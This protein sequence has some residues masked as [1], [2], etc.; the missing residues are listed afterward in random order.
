MKFLTYIRIE[1]R[2]R[3]CSTYAVHWQ[4]VEEKKWSDKILSYFPSSLKLFHGILSVQDSS[5]E[6][7][8][9][10]QLLVYAGTQYIFNFY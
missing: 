7:F 2:I 1:D 6:N 8:T 10:C 5:P 4:T 9:F 3:H